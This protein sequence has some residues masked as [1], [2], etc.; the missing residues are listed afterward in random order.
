MNPTQL[1]KL[2]GYKES[3]FKDN[4][5]APIFLAGLK[6]DVME[7]I[8]EKYVHLKMTVDTQRK[9]RA[10]ALNYLKKNHATFENMK[11]YNDFQ[12]IFPSLFS[13]MK[14]NRKKRS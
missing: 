2:T 12:K 10:D 7:V 1:A 11:I 8:Y 9:M 14:K 13:E 3:L 5:R 4:G 6:L